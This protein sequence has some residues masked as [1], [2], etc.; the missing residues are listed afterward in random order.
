MD[1]NLEELVKKVDRLPTQLT[2]ATKVVVLCSDPQTHIS[3]LI[4]VISS[5][6]SIFCQVL[7]IANSPYFNYPQEITAIEQA[8]I[9]LGSNLLR[10]I[11]LSIAINSIYQSLKV[12]SDFNLNELW[13]HAFLTG[14]VGRALAER[15]DPERKDI[16]FIGGLF[17]D[18]GKLVQSQ[19][20]EKDFL[21]IFIKS[22]RENEKLHI[23]ERRI[24]G[25]H[26]GD[27]GGFL[28]QKWNLPEIV[29][30]MVKFHHFPI[31][32][33]GEDEQLRMVRFIYLSDLLAHFIQNDLQTIAD[34]DKLD[35]QFNQYFTFS[36]EE[37][38]KL[39]NFTKQFISNR[40]TFKQIVQI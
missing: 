27:V 18:I 34:M 28:L 3:K 15:Y 6:L 20:I 7:R 38:A 31:E 32:Y 36:N 14:L 37:F 40:K 24:L 9:V 5:D 35:K 2:V 12:N 33:I 10:D 25:F 13:E 30:Q 39:I 22:R 21:L 8:I 29:V 1:Y 19:I 23:L 11:V 4:E 26:H 17:H 16:L